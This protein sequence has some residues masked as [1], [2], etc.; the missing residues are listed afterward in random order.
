MSALHLP[1][2]CDNKNIYLLITR[3]QREGDEQDVS[4]NMMK[5]KNTQQCYPV[6]NQE[7]YSRLHP[8]PSDSQRSERCY[9]PLRLVKQQKQAFTVHDKNTAVRRDVDNETSTNQVH[10]L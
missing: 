5:C 2:V 1:G 3:G 9:F 7:T 6:G 4:T 10:V 8:Y